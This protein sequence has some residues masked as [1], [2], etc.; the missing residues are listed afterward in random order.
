MGAGAMAM[1]RLFGDRFVGRWGAA[2][3]LRGSGLLASGGI[4]LAM[5]LPLVPVAFLG[6]AA[7]GVGLANAVPIL[8]AA[9]V[10]VPGV[11]PGAGLAAVASLGYAAFLGG[12]PLVEN[13]AQFTSLRFGLALVAILALPIAFGSRALGPAEGKSR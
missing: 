6:F 7:A 8:F 4:L 2:K 9:A 12:R 10:R 1:G 13:D 11:S 3:A 5:A